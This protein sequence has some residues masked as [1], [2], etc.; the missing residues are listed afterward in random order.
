MG[1]RRSC[2]EPARLRPVPPCVSRPPAIAPR[3]TAHPGHA[4]RKPVACGDHTCRTT[5]IECLHAIRDLEN[6]AAALKKGDG[7]AVAALEVL[8][9]GETSLWNYNK[10]W[11]RPPVARAPPPACFCGLRS[12]AVRPWRCRHPC[13][14]AYLCQRRRTRPRPSWFHRSCRRTVGYVIPCYHAHAMRRNQYSRSR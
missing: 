13:R 12:T 5:Y 2:S 7:E 6:H 9:A 1:Q 8:Y 3:R 14:M 4:R 10:V 11:R